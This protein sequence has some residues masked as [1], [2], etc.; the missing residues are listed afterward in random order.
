MEV[1]LVFRDKKEIETVTGLEK[2]LLFVMK[3]F[4]TKIARP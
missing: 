4:D 2:Y 1:F 3:L